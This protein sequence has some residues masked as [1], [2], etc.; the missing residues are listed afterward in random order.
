LQPSENGTEK[1]YHPQPAN[2]RLSNTTSST[3]TAKALLS[4]KGLGGPR[5]RAS[6]SQWLPIPMG[7]TH[8]AILNV[9]HCAQN[10]PGCLVLGIRDV[11]QMPRLSRLGNTLTRT[12]F[13]MLYNMRLTDTQTGLRGIPLAHIDQLVALAGDRY[14]YEMNMLVH[15][16]MLFEGILEVPISTVYFGG[17][18]SS[19]FNAI[20]DGARIYKVLFGSM[21]K[22][23]IASLASFAIDYSFFSGFYYAGGLSTVIATLSARAI[24]ATFNYLM[25][26]HWAFDNPGRALHL[27]AVCRPLRNDRGREQPA[28]AST[29]RRLGWFSAGDEDYRRVPSIRGELHRAKQHGSRYTQDEK[30]ILGQFTQTPNAKFLQKLHLMRQNIQ[31]SPFPIATVLHK[32]IWW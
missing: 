19:H 13:G 21:P 2:K 27:W 30:E 14:E 8:A 20:K 7:N 5:A 15:A 25:N 3:T 22:F 16:D 1:R 29:R 28:H 24:S 26:K 23:L 17:N 12:L 18:T 9:A 31:H 10:N 32:D 4:K 11:K 6:L